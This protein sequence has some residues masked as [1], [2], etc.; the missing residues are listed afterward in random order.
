MKYNLLD[1]GHDFIVG[2]FDV[3]PCGMEVVSMARVEQEEKI[4]TKRGIKL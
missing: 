3:G 1:G 2:A 4:P